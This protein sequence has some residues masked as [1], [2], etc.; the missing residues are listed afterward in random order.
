MSDFP[1][2]IDTFSVEAEQSLIGALLIDPDSFDSLADRVSADDFY[3]DAHRRIFRHVS[4]IA[5]AGKAVDVLTVMDAAERAGDLERIGGLAYLGEIANATPSAANAARYAEIIR[6]RA[7]LRRLL[8]ATVEISDLAME[9]GASIEEKIDFAQAR[10]M[11]LSDAKAK[12]HEPVLASAVLS[13][14]IQRMEDGGMAKP[15]TPTGFVDLD[16]RMNCGMRGG[17]LII[18][19]ARPGMGKAQ[20][21]DSSI[22]LTDGTWRRMGDIAVGDAIASVD[23]AESRVVGVFPQGVKQV[24]KI[25]FSDGR[26][27]FACK[28]H[29]WSVMYRDWAEPRVVDTGM[30]MEMLGKK[31]YQ[32]RLSIDVV[33]GN[34]GGGSLPIDP[35]VLGVLLGD[36]GITGNAVRFSSADEEIVQEVHRRLS[37]FAEVRKVYGKYAYSIV[38]KGAK[39]RSFKDGCR[40]PFG[41][42]YP[43]QLK[44][45][46]LHMYRPRIVYPVRD[47]LAQLGLQGLGS[48]QKFIPSVYFSACREDRLELLRGLMDT[49]G[50]AEA[51]ASVRF[52]SSSKQLAEGVQRLVRSLGGL[53]SITQKNTTFTSKGEKRAGMVAWVCR[54][55]HERAEEFFRLERK[56]VRA[57]RGRNSS[58]RLNVASIEECGEA[59]TQCIQ[60]SHH[61]RLYVTDEYTVTHNTAL[62]VQIATHVACELGKPALFCSQEMPNE[63]LASRA[64]GVIGRVDLGRFARNEMTEDDWSRLSFAASKLHTAQLYFDEQPSLR[65]LD[66]RNKARSVKRKAGTLG[67]LVV[68]YLQLMVGD[69]KAAQENRNA[70]IEKIS[71]GLKSLA[72]ELDIPVIALSQLNRELER[73]PNKRPQMSDLR[74]SGAI[75]QDADAILFIY[76]DEV[77]N[78]DSPDVGMAEV[79]VG[80]C[81]SGRAGGHVGMA[82]TGEYTRF[83]NAEHGWQPQSGH[84][85]AGGGRRYGGDGD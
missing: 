46:D 2:Q 41:R 54:I 85:R 62:A 68:D 18:L 80:K 6:E 30:L 14:V 70:E 8:A 25:S 49:D 60:V 9:P 81:R 20:P 45:N 79:I 75:E 43:A 61:S 31:R 34:F 64:V 29:L 13:A 24:F 72:K 7:M 19:A 50:W 42:R 5:G 26:S 63:Q 3:V 51:H 48:S 38:S 35:Y 10:V 21:L 73:R 55:R 27:T 78:P 17:D 36:G 82:Y 58:V 11:A 65:L 33:S 67:L 53:C 52:T 16:A 37:G 44:H 74:D 47:A 83:E 23:G 77:Y 39:G 56:S 76:R 1:H 59:E 22:L 71:R 12:Q 15:V 4:T 28:E 32:N 57:V 66:V 40:L 84:S 69:G